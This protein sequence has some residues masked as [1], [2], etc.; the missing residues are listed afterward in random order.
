MPPCTY[1]ACHAV[2]ALSG[3]LAASSQERLLG[4]RASSEVSAMVSARAFPDRAKEVRVYI[5]VP[6]GKGELGGAVTTVPERS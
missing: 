6:G 5:S 2:N 1:S 4:L 3:T